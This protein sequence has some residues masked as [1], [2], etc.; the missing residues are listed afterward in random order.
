MIDAMKGEKADL[1]VCDGAPEGNHVVDAVGCQISDLK[2]FDL[3]TGIHDLDAYLHSQLLLA[4]S[5]QPKLY[6]MMY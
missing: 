1:I 6:S 2:M 4:V 5:C 3:V